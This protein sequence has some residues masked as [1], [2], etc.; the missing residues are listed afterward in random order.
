MKHVDLLLERYPCLADCGDAIRAAV[1][2]LTD[3]HKNGN[4]VL[5]CGNGGSAADASHISGEL[6]KGFLL[7]RPPLSEELTALQSVTELAPYAASLQRGICAVALPDQSAVLSAFCNDVSPDA[8]YA[9]L[10]FAMARPGDVVMGLSTSGNSKN[11]LLA[12]ACAKALGIKSI[13]LTG[14]GGG[15][16]AALCDILIDV[17]ETETF[18]VQELHLPVYHAICAQVEDDLFGT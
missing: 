10:V 1:T 2:A 12:V 4:K 6:L 9:Q 11:V 7:K 5:L 15:K 3:M 16:L 18:R 13:A 17:P 8:M 14:K